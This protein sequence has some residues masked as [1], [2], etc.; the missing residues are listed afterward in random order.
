MSSNWKKL[1]AKSTAPA[2]TKKTLPKQHN[3]S[4]PSKFLSLNQLKS[5]DKAPVYEKPATSK[6][7]R[8]ATTSTTTTKPIESKTSKFNVTIRNIEPIAAA[9]TVPI[10][11]A[12]VENTVSKKKRRDR[13]DF[14]D[15]MLFTKKKNIYIETILDKKDLE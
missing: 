13:D 12:N 4:K 7:R 3:N 14:L 2:T 5:S 1:S 11:D 6:H 10:I 8:T 9:L 15:S